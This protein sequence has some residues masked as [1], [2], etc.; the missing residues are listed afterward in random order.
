MKPD[1]RGYLGKHVT[2]VVDRPLGSIHSR[3][4][5]S[6]PYP[7]N[8]GYVPDTLSGDGAPVD[9]YV[10][11][12]EEPVHVARGQVIAVAVREDDIEDKLVVLAEGS[13][14]LARE[15]V[16]SSVEFQERYFKTTLVMPAP[17]E[18]A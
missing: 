5:G 9:A 2:V 3:F 8:Y 14:A 11:G 15:V 16:W 12:I 17:P 4:P 10:L 18:L 6:D 1:L 13:H 7:V